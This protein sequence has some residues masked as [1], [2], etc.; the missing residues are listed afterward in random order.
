MCKQDGRGATG[1]MGAGAHSH[2]RSEV[3]GHAVPKLLLPV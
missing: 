2:S 1:G 3:L